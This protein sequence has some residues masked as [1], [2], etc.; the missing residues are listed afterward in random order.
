MK[1]SLRNEA[2]FLCGVLRDDGDIEV[3]KVSEGTDVAEV[4]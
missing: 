2:L 3:S 4:R 1:K